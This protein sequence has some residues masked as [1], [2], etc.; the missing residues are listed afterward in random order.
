MGRS[1]IISKYLSAIARRGGEARAKS[2]TSDERKAIAI[3]ASKG[4]AKARTLKAKL[5]KEKTTNQP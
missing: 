5:R 2:L 4:A 1:A 3:K